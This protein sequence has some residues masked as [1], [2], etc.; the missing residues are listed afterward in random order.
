MDGKRKTLLGIGSVSHIVLKAAPNAVECADVSVSVRGL[1]AIN[2][3]AECGF[4][5]EVVWVAVKA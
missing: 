1:V 2:F 5:G 3:V 4:S